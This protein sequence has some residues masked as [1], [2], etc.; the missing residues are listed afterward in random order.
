MPSS[1][2]MAPHSWSATTAS[3]G[4]ARRTSRTADWTYIRFH[5]GARGRHGNYSR[6]EIETWAR[7]IAQWRPNTEIYVYFN[8]DWEGY[9]L[10]NALWLKE[11]LS[12]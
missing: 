1:G 5:H 10:R 8:N 2:G 9:A 4:S 6:S 7:R 12:N 3:R 11:H